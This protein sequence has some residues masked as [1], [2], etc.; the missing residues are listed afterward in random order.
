MASTSSP[1]ASISGS[2]SGSSSAPAPSPLKTTSGS[3]SKSNST[4]SSHDAQ[5]LYLSANFAHNP[6]APFAVNYDQEVY[7]Q[8]TAG[9]DTKKNKTPPQLYREEWV[10]RALNPAVSDPRG[11]PS[12]LDFECA[13]NQRVR[14]R[15]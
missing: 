8:L 7:L 9:E 12:P 5:S 13:E 6:K 10:R 3:A 14:D 11:D 4:A 1:S 2:G 15:F